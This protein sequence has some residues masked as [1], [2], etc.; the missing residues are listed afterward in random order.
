MRVSIQIGELRR[1]HDTIAKLKSNHLHLV[2]LGEHLYVRSQAYNSHSSTF[3]EVICDCSVESEGTV[4]VDFS[5]FRGVV[6]QC[7]EVVTLET[8]DAKLHVSSG[9]LRFTLKT[10]YLEFSPEFQ[11][12]KGGRTA[13]FSAAQIHDAAS[14]SCFMDLSSTKDACRMLHL[15]ESS[16]GGS[17]GCNLGALKNG[18][19]ECVAVPG[20][21][22]PVLTYLKHDAVCTW[23]EE[24]FVA[25]VP[26]FGVS[27][28]TRMVLMQ[29]TNISEMIERVRR[30]GIYLGTVRP[31]E[32]LQRIREASVVGPT[33][34]VD[35]SCGKL[36]FVGKLPAEM[37]YYGELPI[38][39][40]K[41]CDCDPK[42]Y[43]CQ[44]L[45]K[46]VEAF[47]GDDVEITF[48]PFLLLESGPEGGLGLSMIVGGLK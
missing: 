48:G 21:I 27:M 11:G 32:L 8:K 47:K 22:W 37:E 2:A 45:T 13:T 1:A 41:E 43:P 26:E 35:Y 29:P 5:L 4:N 46:A 42:N 10:V 44:K 28:S 36:R 33:V 16:I 25:V 39:G 15:T 24:Y 17:D 9:S 38:V 14:V 40:G 12:V 19:V 7:T 6:H 3:V 34:S 18:A 31:Q 23:T 30:A 20:Q